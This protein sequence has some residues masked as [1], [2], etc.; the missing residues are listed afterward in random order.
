VSVCSACT[1]G[2]VVNILGFTP[3]YCYY[4]VVLPSGGSLL[5]GVLCLICNS[6]FW[7]D[8]IKVMSSTM[9]IDVR[10]TSLVSLAT[11]FGVAFIRL[12]GVNLVFLMIYP[13]LSTT[14]PMLPNPISYSKLESLLLHQHFFHL[15]SCFLIPFLRLSI[16][17]LN[18]AK[19]L[20]CRIG[21]VSAFLGST[22][23][24][25]L[26]FIFLLSMTSLLLYVV[27]APACFLQRLQC[28]LVKTFL[29]T[30]PVDS[31]IGLL[32]PFLPL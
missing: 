24:R 27:Y 9:L 7:L 22:E 15:V 2:A 17:L 31:V 14:F 20:L 5:V 26:C 1:T 30:L 4:C 13:K 19:K 8:D 32:F 29:R 21:F 12:G 6:L 28:F 3:H 18:C 25:F 23:T 10:H 11:I 16:L